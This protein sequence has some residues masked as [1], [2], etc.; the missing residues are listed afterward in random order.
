MSELVQFQSA[1]EAALQDKL[2]VQDENKIVVPRDPWEDRLQYLRANPDTAV[3]VT[4]PTTRPG[5]NRM[6]DAFEDAFQLIGGPARLALWADENPTEFFKLCG[7]LLPKPIEQ[8]IKHE[9][10]M[11]IVH[12]LPRGKLDE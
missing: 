9:G 4:R 2:K 11:K 3:E 12:V 6:Q 10:G 1:E 7:K 8:E 5:R